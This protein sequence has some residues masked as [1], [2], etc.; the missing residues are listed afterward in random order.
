M[1]WLLLLLIVNCVSLDLDYD[2]DD[3]DEE[4][5]EETEKP[6]K[7]EEAE[8]EE[9]EE[10]EEEEQQ[11]EVPGEDT[12]WVSS[13]VRDVAYYLRAHKFND[14]DR[15]YHTNEDLAPRK[16]LSAEFQRSIDPVYS[17]HGSEQEC[18]RLRRL[19]WVGAQPFLGPLERFQWRTSASYYM[20]WF[21]MNTETPL[22]H[23]EERCDNFA[24]CLDPDFND[25]NKDPRASSHIPYQC[26]TYSFCPD[27]C[28]PR[29]HYFGM[30]E[31]HNADSN[32]CLA[33]APHR[34]HMCSFNFTRNTDFVS[35]VL[36]R[37]NVSCSCKDPGYEWDSRFGM[38][39]GK[40][41]LR[42]HDDF[43]RW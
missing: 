24:N 1:S 29:K 22:S 39:V 15:R 10:V 37:W 41:P 2:D 34:H 19:D 42:F 18:E 23:F 3:F 8:E 6:V 25:S 32:P 20:C 14:F 36:N 4:E 33:E 26:A 11:T 9:R 7:D 17:G 16:V 21:A 5:E 31:C 27:P 35:I 13:A 43:N 12:K 30:D 38:C 28:C 40:I